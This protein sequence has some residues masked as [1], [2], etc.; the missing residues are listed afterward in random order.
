MEST[1]PEIF[2][3]P[4]LSKDK[5][6]GFQDAKAMI[7]VNKSVSSQNIDLLQPPEGYNDLFNRCKQVLRQRPDHDQANTQLKLFLC[8]LCSLI[9]TSESMTASE[10]SSAQR[11]M[12][13]KM[14]ELH[15]EDAKL[16]EAKE[17]LDMALGSVTRNFNCIVATDPDFL[18]THPGMKDCLQ[19]LVFTYDAA[20]TAQAHHNNARE[21]LD[22]A[23]KRYKAV[24]AKNEIEQHIKHIKAK[25]DL[26]LC[27][28]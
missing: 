10:L 14:Q 2:A 5:D 20:S 13:L 22:L 11:E 24:Q 1:E 12:N 6:E 25:V 19:S 28:Q 23:E 9:Q 15:R 18:A 17:S 21:Y 27:L 8:R 16:K 4:S 3:T 26:N 7:E